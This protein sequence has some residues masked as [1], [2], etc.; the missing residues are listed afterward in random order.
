[1]ANKTKVVLGSGQGSMPIDTKRLPE[2][3]V[4]RGGVNEFKPLPAMGRIQGE[5]EPGMGQVY[6]GGPSGRMEESMGQMPNMMGSMPR[7]VMMD[8]RINPDGSHQGRNSDN[9]FD[10]WTRNN[11]RMMPMDIGPGSANER[12]QRAYR[13]EFESRSG[14]GSRGDGQYRESPYGDSSAL[15]DGWLQGGGMGGA[16]DARESMLGLDNPRR[17]T[18]PP[19]APSPRSGGK[20]PQ[21]P[22]RKFKK[23]RLMP[24]KRRPIKKLEGE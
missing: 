14:G 12:A 23:K 21:K 24:R 20:P 18:R 22:V 6:G 8:A 19:L 2:P 15:I 13:E 4:A 17:I 7:G 1:M 9:E 5:P 10:E 11:P 3:R 16:M